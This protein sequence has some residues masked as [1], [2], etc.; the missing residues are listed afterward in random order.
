MAPS[1]F[2]GVRVGYLLVLM[3]GLTA[4]TLSGVIGTGSSMLL[5]PVRVMLFGPQ[6]AVPVM[7]IAAIMGNFGK[8]L[9]WWREIDWRACGASSPCCILK[10][11]SLDKRR[12]QH[13]RT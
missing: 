1:H 3:V 7:S 9:A 4:G 13:D 6:Q 2:S 5:M 11:E 12:E 10:P 8:V